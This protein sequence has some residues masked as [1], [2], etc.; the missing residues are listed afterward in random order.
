MSCALNGT[1]L[2]NE[3]CHFANTKT[4]ENNDVEQNGKKNTSSTRCACFSLF[5]DSRRL[6]QQLNN[7]FVLNAGQ[8]RQANSS[9]F[10][11]LFKSFS[12]DTFSRTV[13]SIYS[14]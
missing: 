11:V 9:F 10:I 4:V 5:L 13:C 12:A 3:N 1:V 8:H 6:C 2:L 7:W 14:H